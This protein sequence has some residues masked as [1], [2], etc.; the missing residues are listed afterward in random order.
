MSCLAVRTPEGDFFFGERGCSP[1]G[2]M[3]D[4]SLEL[5]FQGALGK[6][7]KILDG[8]SKRQGL[9]DGEDARH[10]LS[11]SNPLVGVFGHRVDVMGH[12][13]PLLCS[14]PA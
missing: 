13:D 7:E 8:F 11:C 5:T 12:Q 4:L 2:E 1:Q 14:R 10:P 3:E 6:E 9:A